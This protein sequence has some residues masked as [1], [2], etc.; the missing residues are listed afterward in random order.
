ML[1]FIKGN[2]DLII[3]VG[4]IAF[5]FVFFLIVFVKRLKS[6]KNAKT[7]EERTKI[8]NELKSAAYGFITVAENLFSDVPKSGSSKLLYVLNKIK[9]LCTMNNVEYD[10]Q[11]WTDFVNG[12]IATSNGVVESKEQEK[13]KNDIIEKIKAEIPVF[14][15]ETEKLF[16]SIPESIEYQIEHVLKYVAVACDG[17][18]INVFND[19]DWR[20]YIYGFYTKQNAV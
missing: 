14:I 20:G 4:S 9:E 3:A 6:L 16:S 2:Y 17:Y 19:Y 12:V 13:S 10:V 1:D 7:D 8:K 18:D 5:S 15:A 11:E